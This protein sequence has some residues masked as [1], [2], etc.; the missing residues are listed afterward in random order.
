MAAISTA[1][2]FLL[3]HRPN[4]IR[5]MAATP[6]ADDDVAFIKTAYAGILER[7][8]DA[9]GL[10][11][12]LRALRSGSSRQEVLLA[13]A[14]SEE[15]T[16][17]SLYRPGLRGLVDDWWH[18]RTEIEPVVRPICFLHTM[19]T[20]GTALG[21]ALVDLAGPRPHLTDL[22]VDQLVCLPHA[23][24]DQVALIAGHLPYEAVE[25]LP[26]GIALCTIVRDPLDRTLS[27]HA[28]FNAILAD[29]GQQPVAIDEFL[30]LDGYRPL[31]ENYQA[32]QLVHR[33]GLRD[34]WGTFSPSARAAARGLHGPDAAYPLQS[35]FD[36]TP[37]TL[38][39][40]ELRTAALQRL[41]TL[42]FVGT[43]DDLQ[44]LIGHL[45]EF[46]DRP[47]P[48][49]VPRAACHRVAPQARRSVSGARHA[50]SGRDD[51]RRRALRAGAAHEWRLRQDALTSRGCVSPKL[52]RPR[53]ALEA[54]VDLGGD[55]IVVHRA[56]R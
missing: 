10:D 32:R 51:D 53:V 11:D 30:T 3:Q 43:T 19:K 39:G 44:L 31:W 56:A 24:T 48:A 7:P 26:E 50:H 20:G 36:S 34:A 41:A 15:A 14:Q 12:H 8:P 23:L 47:P 37:M 6:S 22:M 2:A 25:L 52:L 9:Q 29:R 21:R 54:A 42:D 33:V 16:T 27:H 13:I 49:P 46:W 4:T 18:A 5:W 40:D 35:L 17:L 1:I 55:R 28:H 38:A 45:A